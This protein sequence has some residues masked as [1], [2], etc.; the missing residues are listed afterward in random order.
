MKCLRLAKPK[1][2]ILNFNHRIKTI[3][4]QHFLHFLHKLLKKNNNVVAAATVMKYIFVSFY[5]YYYYYFYKQNSGLE[6][7]LL[8]IKNMCYYSDICYTFR[9]FCILYLSIRLFCVTQTEVKR[10]F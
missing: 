3:S 6:T 2:F 5:Y 7:R 1:E 8:T 9:I 4:K 10:L